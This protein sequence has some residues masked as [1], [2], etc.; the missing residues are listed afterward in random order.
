MVQLSEHKITNDEHNTNASAK[1]VILVDDSGTTYTAGSAPIYTVRLD[2]TS[3]AG[4][5]YVGKAVVSS[6]EASAVWQIQ[7]I[8]ETGAV[9]TIKFADGNTNFDNVWNN[10]TSLTYL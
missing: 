8:D 5:T 9:M 6:S 10:R 7:K 4:I 1:Q 2:D 3:T